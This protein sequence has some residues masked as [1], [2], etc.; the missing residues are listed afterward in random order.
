[1]SPKELTF[2]VLNWFIKLALQ[3]ALFVLNMLIKYMALLSLNIL[4]D[5]Y[6]VVISQG[7]NKATWWMSIY[8]EL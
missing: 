4:S 6:F 8:S 5:K 3:G 2:D 7:N 1:M